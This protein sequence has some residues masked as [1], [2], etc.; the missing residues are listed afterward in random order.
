[1]RIISASTRAMA[2]PP[3]TGGDSDLA[4]FVTRE[5]RARRAVALNQIGRPIDAGAELRAGVA[6][7]PDGA[8]RTL[9]MKLIYAL[10]PAARPMSGEVVLQSPAGPAA[11]SSAFYPTPALTPVGGYVVDKALV[12]AVVWQESRFNSLAVSPVGA[13]GLMQ[14]MPPT[15]GD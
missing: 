4:G 3:S 8:S 12:Y 15:A 14:L 6:E 5:P 13:I 2:A 10:N 1:E 11:Q 9:W 7:A